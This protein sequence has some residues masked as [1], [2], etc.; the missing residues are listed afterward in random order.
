MG[1]YEPADTIGTNKNYIDL[2]NVRDDIYFLF[3]DRRYCYPLFPSLVDEEEEE[4]RLA[5]S[6]GPKYTIKKAGPLLRPHLQDGEHVFGLH[7]VGTI[8]SEI[9][10]GDS[11]LD[12]YT[13][14]DEQTFED[15]WTRANSILNAIPDNEYVK[16]YGFQGKF[17]ELHSRDIKDL[18]WV[19]V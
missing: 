16:M 1:I 8:G 5:V 3:I 14:L 9:R 13:V 18:I 4:Y 10:I 19:G 17:P 15:I 11:W 6:F 2:R 12:S 7:D